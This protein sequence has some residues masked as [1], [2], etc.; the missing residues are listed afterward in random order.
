MSESKLAIGLKKR[1]N[2][3]ERLDRA[4]RNKI[5]SLPLSKN[6]VPTELLPL[7]PVVL[8]Y[9]VDLC[10]GAKKKFCY[11]YNVKRKQFFTVTNARDRGSFAATFCQKIK[12]YESKEPLFSRVGINFNQSFDTLGALKEML[13]KTPEK[14]KDSGKKRKLESDDNSSLERPKRV[15]KPSPKLLEE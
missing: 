14:S 6:P 4:T 1:K 7:L 11:R 3:Y 5:L 2:E 9:I 13:E 10:L 15:R 8:M 12:S